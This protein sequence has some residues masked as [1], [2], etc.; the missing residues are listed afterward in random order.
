MPA[1]AASRVVNA[2]RDEVWAALSDIAKAGRWNAAWSSIEFS[3]KQTHGPE[4]RFRAR[5]AEGDTYEFVITAWVAPEYIE[6][7]PVRDE[8]ERHGITLESQ[9]FV[10]EPEGDDATRVELIAR[11]STHG[12]RGW[13]LGL[14]FWKGYQKHGLNTALDGLSSVFEPEDSGE[15]VEEEAP[16]SE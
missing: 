15:E 1:T 3:S 11:A 7:S 4:T 5:T 2:P 9:A 12:L 6:F 8:T 16:A 14:L 13:A 10:L